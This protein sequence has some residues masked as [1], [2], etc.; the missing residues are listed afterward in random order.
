MNTYPFHPTE[1]EQE[2]VHT[3]RSGSSIVTRVAGVTFNGRQASIACLRTGDPLVLRREPINL[4][5]RNAIRVE[6]LNGQQIGY[7]NRHLAAQLAPF[8]DDY[9]RAVSASVQCLTG[10]GQGGYSLGVVI[11]FCVP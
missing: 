6:R 9:G 10:S 11:S 5:D 7:L 8:F 4:Y 1:Y 3:Y 2:E